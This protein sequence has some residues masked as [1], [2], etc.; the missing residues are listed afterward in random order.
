MLLLLLAACNPWA[1]VHEREAPWWGPA[2]GLPAELVRLPEGEPVGYWP[3]IVVG[4]EAIE[5][6]NRAW[7]L[8]LPEPLLEALEPEDLERLLV[9]RRLDL[10][11]DAGR[12]PE[13][14]QR[15][16]FIPALYDTLIEVVE[17]A[18]WAAELD[19]AM[20]FEDA[21]LVLPAPGV[22]S[23]TLAQVF[24]T[25]GQAQLG[26]AALGG[27]VD[28]RVRRVSAAG[29]AAACAGLVILEANAEGPML[30]GGGR[31]LSLDGACPSGA[32]GATLERL[33]TLCEPRWQALVQEAFA[34]APQATP[35][36]ESRWRCAALLTSLGGEGRAEDLLRA[37]SEL[38]ARRDLARQVYTLGGGASGCADPVDLSQPLDP[39]TLDQVC[40]AARFQDLLVAWTSGEPGVRSVWLPRLQRAPAAQGT[41]E[42]AEGLDALPNEDLDTLL[43]DANGGAP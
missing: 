37:L 5:V 22:P 8:S 42:G 20:A 26:G 33:I 17:A 14:A 23:Q 15:G 29:D 38:H 1:E 16:L 9:E 34:A 18:K 10:P 36:P 11:L 24:Y 41:L 13:R 30:S 7:F 21:V 2:S 27:L 32:P 35:L 3:R 28:D 40:S 19:E 43:D 6:D 39:A 31:A 4:A 25:A 12:I